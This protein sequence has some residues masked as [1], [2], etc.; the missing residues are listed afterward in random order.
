V[1]R[2]VPP[3]DNGGDGSSFSPTDLLGASLATL[4]SANAATDAATSFALYTVFHF[5]MFVGIGLLLLLPSN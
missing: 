1:L 5:A 2:T 4:F 3:R